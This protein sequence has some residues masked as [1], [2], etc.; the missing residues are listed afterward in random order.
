MNTSTGPQVVLYGD[1]Q[2]VADRQGVK[3]FELSISHSLDVVVAVC[4]AKA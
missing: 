3:S 1:A 2:K 4:L